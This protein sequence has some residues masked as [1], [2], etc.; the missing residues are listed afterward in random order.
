M[1]R[2]KPAIRES[3][4]RPAMSAAAPAIR[5]PTRSPVPESVAAS[6]E[7]IDLPQP[8]RL[9]DH[10][11]EA[12]P[13]AGGGERPDRCQRGSPARHVEAG[14]EGD[15]EQGSQGVGAAVAEHDL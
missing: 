6:T 10:L 12:D 11:G 15:S 7:F 2:P 1:V 8:W 14:V 5:L 9:G 13:L 4:V 3:T